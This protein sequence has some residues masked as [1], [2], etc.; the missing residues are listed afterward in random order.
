MLAGSSNAIYQEVEKRS[1][2]S[3]GAIDSMSSSHIA[4]VEH[5]EQQVVIVS[6][7]PKIL[8]E[9]GD[10]GITCKVNSFSMMTKSYRVRRGL[11]TDVG[12]VDKGKQVLDRDNRYDVKV[13]L[14]DEAF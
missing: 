13:H 6:A 8:L 1:A 3:Q 9:P 7:Q 12:P 10:L 14:A 11:H 2:Q 4:D 5:A